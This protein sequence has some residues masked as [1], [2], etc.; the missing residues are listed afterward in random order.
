LSFA[1]EGK[2]KK[3]HCRQ[4]YSRRTACPAYWTMT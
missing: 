1:E 2:E 3:G 4:I